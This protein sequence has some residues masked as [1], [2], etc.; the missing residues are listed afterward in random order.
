MYVC[1][2]VCIIN[3]SLWDRAPRDCTEGSLFQGSI[4]DNPTTEN[5]VSLMKIKGCINTHQVREAY[6]YTTVKEHVAGNVK[7]SKGLI[8]PVVSAILI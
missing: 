6:M 4:N 5:P 1:M 8:N 2:Y 7:S 3:T